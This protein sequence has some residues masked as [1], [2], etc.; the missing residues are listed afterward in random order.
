MSWWR[1]STA[2]YWLGVQPARSS[3][4]HGSSRP[5]SGDQKPRFRGQV[6][7]LRK[8]AL[9]VVAMM[10]IA[11]VLTACGE[12]NVGSGGKFGQGSS[13]HAAL[14]SEPTPAPTKAPAAPPTAQQAAARATPAPAPPPAAQPPRSR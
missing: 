13:R 11:A 4:I 7:L 3:T 8:Y 5:F 12:N 10:S 14:R 1:W 6:Q 9:L 2:P